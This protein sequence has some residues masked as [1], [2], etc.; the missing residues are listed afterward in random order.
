MRFGFSSTSSKLLNRCSK[1]SVWV[2]HQTAH[3]YPWL[4]GIYTA[5]IATTGWTV[6]S[7][8]PSGSGGGG[9]EGR[10]GAQVCGCVGRVRGW[11]RRWQFAERRL[12]IL[13]PCAPRDPQAPPFCVPPLH[14][15]ILSPPPPPLTHSGGT[16]GG[17]GLVTA[18]TRLA[19]PLTPPT[20]DSPSSYPFLTIPCQRWAKVVLWRHGK[21]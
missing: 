18:A 15:T 20:G 14:L 6:Y 12:V 19:P 17:R 1:T 16:Q 4:P 3:V 2:L 8:I 7:D 11:H 21:G 13:L 5:N 10:G 9:G